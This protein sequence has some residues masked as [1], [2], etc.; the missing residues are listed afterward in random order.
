[1][2]GTPKRRWSARTA[3]QN[4]TS[5]GCSK[6]PDFS[7]AQPWRL[8]HPPALSLPRQPLRPR[9]RLFTGKAAASDQIWSP[10]KLARVRCPQDSPVSPP[11]HATFSPAHP[12]ARRTCHAPRRGPSSSPNLNSRE[13]PRLPFTR[14]TF[15]PAQPRA[16]RDALLS[17]AST[18]SPCAFC[19]QE[20]H[21]A[22]PSPSFLGCALREHRGLT[23]PSLPAGGLFQHHARR[24]IV[25]QP[26]RMPEEQ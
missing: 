10:S 11:L 18:V 2:G 9:T 21:L 4:N 20:G 19:E 14:A 22:A 15:S 16:R 3:Q 5:A 13:W 17:Q 12:L 24:R 23:G 1:M 25:A 26:D 7:P 6:R 8:F